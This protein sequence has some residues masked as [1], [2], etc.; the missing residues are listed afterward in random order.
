MANRLAE[1]IANNL[2]GAVALPL[3]GSDARLPMIGGVD[4]V[5][6]VAVVK[7]GFG[8]EGLR[9]VSYLLELGAD[10]SKGLVRRIALRRFG[11]GEDAGWC[12]WMRCLMGLRR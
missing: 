8:T 6:F 4:S 9:E 3:S 1:V 10:G 12:R 2:K 11:V 5:R 7:T